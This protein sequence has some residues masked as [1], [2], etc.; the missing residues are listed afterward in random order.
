MTKEVASSKSLQALVQRYQL[1]FDVLKKEIAKVVVGQEKIINALIEVLVSHAHVLVEGVPG[2]AKTLIVK[3]FATITGCKFSRIQF[4]PDLLPSDIIGITTYEEGKGF[5]TIK[6]P[7]FAN[8]VLADEIN[9]APPKVQSALLEAMQERQVTIGKETFK[10][11]KP[12]LVMATQNPIESLGTYKLPEAQLDRFMY[13]L[14]MDYPDIDEEQKIL[15]RNITVRSFESFGL[16]PVISPQHILQAQKDVNLIAMSSKVERYLLRL[17]DATRRPKK[18]GIHLGRYI[19]YGASPR[20]DISIYI[21]SKAHAL[22]KG[23]TF[24]TPQDVKEV[25]HNALR[26]RII[27]NYEGQAEEISTDEIIDEILRKVP[28]V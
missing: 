19:E 28:V 4:T 27:L 8:F 12:F 6:G 14:L 1:M 22:V 23:K 13:K 16:K 25:A 7:V 11:P 3:S 10:L 20:G 26:H 9:R 15:H 18:Y 24:V 2:I 17:V 21:G 5:Y